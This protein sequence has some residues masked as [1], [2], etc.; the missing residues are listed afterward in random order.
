MKTYAALLAAASNLNQ[1]PNAKSLPYLEPFQSLINLSE[2]TS[3]WVE[4][5]LI[6]ESLEELDDRATYWKHKFYR[7][8]LRSAR[9]V[10]FC[11][12]EKEDYHYE[13]DIIEDVPQLHLKWCEIFHIRRMEKWYLKLTAHLD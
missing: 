10:K 13:E 5:N 12:S 4:N 11:K 7:Q 2:L 9:R 8:F 3:D 6:I 1:N